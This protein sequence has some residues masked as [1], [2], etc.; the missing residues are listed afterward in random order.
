MSIIKNIES[1]L[2]VVQWDEVDDSL[3]TTYTVTWTDGKL[4]GTAAVEE[5]TSYTIT[6]LALDTVYT[7]A[8]TAA[9]RCGDGPEFLTRITFSTD[10]TS[11]T[12]TISPTVTASTTPMTTTVNPSSTSTTMTT[13]SITT[14]VNGNADVSSSRNSYTTLTTTVENPGTTVTTNIANTPTTDETSKFTIYVVDIYTVAF[15]TWQ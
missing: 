8:V 7:I 1:L 11:T 13:N 3:H 6:G 4:L 12:S 10:T 2:V 15:I 9:N 5:H 14:T